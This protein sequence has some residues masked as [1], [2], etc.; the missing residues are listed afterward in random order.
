MNDIIDDTLVRHLI[1]TQF[2]QWKD[3]PIKPIA[4]SGWDNRTFHLG[5]DMLVRLPS[6][7]EYA[8]QVEKEQLWLPKLAPLLPLQIPTPLAIGQPEKGYPWKW[9]IYYWIEGDPATH[10]NIA[11]L[12]GFAA[13]LA[14]FLVALQRIDTANGPLPGPHN[15]YRGGALSIYD[16]EVRQALITLKD[17][18]DVY[19]ATEVWETALATT[20]QHLP[21]WIMVILVQEIYL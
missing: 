3:L 1:A 10:A 8:S 11:D 7:K 14:Q 21:V 2:P 6:R 19:A 12:K 16:S 18:I 4:L 13:S 15:F 9:S 20:W 17:R 5:E